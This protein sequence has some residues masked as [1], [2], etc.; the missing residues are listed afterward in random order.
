V[1]L[2]LSSAPERPPDRPQLKNNELNVSKKSRSNPVRICLSK[3]GQS[4]PKGSQAE[5]TEPG[6]L[7]LWLQL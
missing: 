5:D 7:N 6:N 1:V 3:C 2:N 4:V